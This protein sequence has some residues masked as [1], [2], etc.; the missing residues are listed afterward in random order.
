LRLLQPFLR[1]LA[2]VL[3]VVLACAGSAH[4]APRLRLGFDDDSLKWMTRPNR[5]IA[6]D[7]QLGAT[8][9]RITIPWRR[10]EVRPRP[11]VRTYLR[12]AARA[13]AMRQ[14]VVIAVY[15]RAAEAPTDAVSRD[16]YCAYVGRLL[17]RVPNL[18]AIVIWNEANSPRYW[19]AASGAAGYE[20]LLASCWDVLHA[21][22]S[23][24]NVIDSTASHH[25]PARFILEL[26]AAYRAS[27]RQRPIVDTFGHNPYPESASEDPWVTH[28]TLPVIGEGDYAKLIAALTD[29]FAFTAQRVPS[30]TW[31]RLWY[32]EDG[33]QTAVPWTLQP[34]Y[35]GHENDRHVL[36]AL[37]LADTKSQS[38]QLV[39]AISL[40]YCQP[41]V[42]AFFNFELYDEHRLAGWQSGVLYTNGERKASFPAFKQVAARSAAG[43]ID[44]STVQGAPPEPD[45]P[46]SRRRTARV[47]TAVGAPSDGRRAIRTRTGDRGRGHRACGG[48]SE[49]SYTARPRS[50]RARARRR[51]RGHGRPVA[52][53]RRRG[54][55]A[56]RRR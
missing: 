18:A 26:G 50:S 31:T 43:A 33:F 3:L 42:G 27:G 28:K 9:T 38:E 23:N 20:A 5:V 4:A 36:P 37:A 2:P 45:Q 34:F 1:R 16:E 47:L 10:G 30:P 55:R 51:G 48:A 49:G 25:E 6:I 54:T 29:A 11:V 15:N 41:A 46:L 53:R 44:C 56:S 13:L 19:P 52:R 7:R 22:K 21:I 12:R 17:G 32:L 24:V 40:A 14:K 39:A 8:F 35:S